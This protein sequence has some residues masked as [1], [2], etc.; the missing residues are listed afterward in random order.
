MD[1]K[2]KPLQGSGTFHVWRSPDDNFRHPFLKLDSDCEPD[3]YPGIIIVS[4]EHYQRAFATGVKN[5]EKE[6]PHLLEQ[7]Q[8]KP[9]AYWLLEQDEK[10]IKRILSGLTSNPVFVG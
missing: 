7:I 6:L 2:Q 1:I 4:D 10:E 5:L 8:G 3:K 9:I